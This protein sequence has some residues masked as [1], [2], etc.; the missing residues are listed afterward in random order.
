MN[1]TL[2]IGIIIVAAI[3]VYILILRKLKPG[4]ALMGETIEKS[5]DKQKPKKG[6][7]EQEKEQEKEKEKEQEKEKT[8]WKIIRSKKPEKKP[9]SVCLHYFG[10]LNTVPKNTSLPDNCLGCSRIMQCLAK[11]DEEES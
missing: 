10:Y 3:P 4:A 8:G 6:E 2:L 11:T 1:S 5:P 9:S 7:K